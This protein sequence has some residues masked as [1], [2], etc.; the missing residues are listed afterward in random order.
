M[1]DGGRVDGNADRQG[2]GE[3]PQLVVKAVAAP[4]MVPAG[5][6]AHKMADFIHWAERIA[7]A[8]A[9]GPSSARVRGHLKATAKSTWELVSW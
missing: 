7:D 3:P 8:I 2:A 9:H 6:D 5:E 4:E 1:N